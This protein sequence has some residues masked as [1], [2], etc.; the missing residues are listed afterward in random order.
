MSAKYKVST[1]QA[2]I[3]KLNLG[4]AEQGAGDFIVGNLAAAQDVAPI[5]SPST[6]TTTQIATAFNALIAALN[7]HVGS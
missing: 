2:L 1:I 4:T 5:A 6:A 7:T 3:N